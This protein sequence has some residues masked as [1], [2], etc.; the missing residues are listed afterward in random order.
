MAGVVEAVDRSKF[1]SG[2]IEAWHRIEV[3]P[4]SGPNLTLSVLSLSTEEPLPAPGQVCMFRY[5]TN[6]LQ[7]R[8]GQAIMDTMSCDPLASAAS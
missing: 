4:P 8:H 2:F 7:S 6:G 5:H 3:R 1:G